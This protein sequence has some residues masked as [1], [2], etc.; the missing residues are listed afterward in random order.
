MLLCAVVTIGLLIPPAAAVEPAP[1]EDLYSPFNEAQEWPDIDGN[2]IVWEDDRHDNK[3][4]YF[5]TV[6]KFRAD[7]YRGMQY[8]S[9]TG[10]RITDDPASQERPSISGNYIVWQD[11]RHGNWDI[12]LYDRSTGIETQLTT[13]TGKQWLPIVR[14]NYV[15]WYDDSSGDTNIVLYDIAAGSVKDV[16]ECDAK[17]TIPGGD[18]DTEF[19]PALSEKYVAWVEEA[20]ERIRYY[21][22]ND[23]EIKG[24]VSTGTAIQS[25]PSL[26]GSVVAWEDNRHGNPDIYMTDLDDPSGG[27]QRI[28]SDSADQV[29]PAI[30]GSIIVW[31][32]KRVPARSI[33]MYDLSAEK[34][35]SVVLSEDKDDE[36]LYPAVSGN[37]IV[38]QRGRE[39]DSNLYIF[40]Y[41]PGAPVE[42]I[43]D[44]VTVTPDTA[45]LEIDGTEQFTATAF[46]QFGEEMAGAEFAWACSN[47]TV[48]TI[49]DTGFFTAHAAGTT[50]VT[51]TAEDIAGTATVT[52]TADEPEEPVLDSIEVEPETVTLEIDGTQ[53]FAATAL[54]QFEEEM[55]GIAFNWSCD[56]ETVGEIDTDGIFTALAAGTATITATAE[57]IT[58]TATVTVTDEEP[59]ATEITIEPP[60]ATLDVNE[61]VT[62]EATVRDQFGGEVPGVS[63]T[64]SCDNETVGAINESSGFFTAHAAGTATVTATAGDLSET[65]TITVTADEPEEPV[66][67]R[68]EV[69]PDTATLDVGDTEQFAAIA[70]DE[71]GLEMTGVE[72]AWSCDNE[73]IG[74]V[75]DTGLFS[76]LASGTATVTASAGD[77]SGTAT[78]TVNADEP[79]E[80]VLTRIT[81]TPPGA[82]LD[83]ED[84]Q[85]FMVTGYDQDDNVMP[86]G[87]ID[88]ACSDEAVGTVDEDGCFT[89]LAAGTATVTATAGNCS[90]EATITVCEEEPLLAKIAV[91]PSKATLEVDDELEFDAIAFDRFGNIVEDA[92]VIWECCDECVGEIDESSG[93]FTA[94]GGGTATITACGDGAEGTAS[95][96]V[97][98]NDPVVTS[99]VV[100]PSAVTLARNDTATFTATALDQN[101]CGMS[102]VTIEWE[103]SDKTVGDVDGTGFFE[104]LAAGTAT[105]TAT[106]DGVAGTADVEVTDES[107]G[108]VVSPSAIILDVDETW[109]FNA[110]VYD[111]QDNA[112][113]TVAWSCGNEGVGTIT[114]DGGLFTAVCEGITSVTATVA[115]ENETATG[116][117][118]VTVRSTAPE[119]ARIEVS[120]SC[121][122]I[123]AG[124]CL[125]L[126]ARGFDQYGF[127]MDVNVTWKSSDLCVGEIDESS[128]VFTAKSA[129]TATLTASADGVCDSACVTV[130]PSLPVPACIEVE[131]P[132]ATLAAGGTREFTATVFDQCENVMDWVRVAW[133]C[134][135][136]DVGTIDRSG[137]FAAFAE[138]SADVTA[139]AGGVEGTASVAVTAAPTTDPT[140]DPTPDP[141]Q[142]PANPG[143][144]KRASSSGGG[145]PGP[146]FFAGICEDLKGGET[147]TFS[148]IDITSIGSIAITASDNIPKLLM[149]VKETG[150][151]NLAAP[152]GGSTYEYV[153]IALSWAN[154]NRVG[155]AT[156]TFTVPAKWLEEHDMLPQD[157]RLMRYVDGGW[158]ILETEV[159]GEEDGNYCFRATTPGFSTF[160]IAAMPENATVTTETNVTTE[161]TGTPE[162]AE[163]MTTGPTVAA[164]TTPA[165]PLVYAPL[166]AP[167]AFLLWA[168]KRR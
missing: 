127:P 15:A 163:T 128:G 110:N 86:A 81:L 25:W 113:S 137:L 2:L 48:G 9:Y 91:V 82:T 132:D 24:A 144:N 22:I 60:E 116:T 139:C 49:D 158:Q 3:D 108:I 121:F 16:I 17:M 99:I 164:T 80:P 104:A 78:V 98:C 37:T 57:D 126:T 13:D 157:V 62:F 141:T 43:L 63:V 130:D 46:D 122:C 136:D 44:R 28:T 5:G 160:A 56:N 52:V 45:T 165:A 124:N 107:T 73:T 111:L 67:E 42:P 50:D 142:P 4:I 29:A 154:P 74:T 18:I 90:A 85:R 10:E 92:E 93:V 120:P 53:Q 148:G 70:F 112:G 145:D 150:C 47:T 94:L 31:E 125:A 6:D 119:L 54:D 66:L 72:F 40:V 1:G 147:H 87:E 152:P 167:L 12:Y 133:S 26:Y 114:A 58:G 100:T 105:V 59:A 155:D 75:D 103:C 153:E 38:W 88:W 161:A 151:P 129:G 65:A 7:P 77:V 84:V 30:S 83:V 11:Y 20:G 131:P 162:G 68:I 143:S 149:T 101:G 76:A 134:S 117:A 106:A 55:T 159:V 8:S 115:G 166:L 140:T 123:P 69:E 89:A 64:W 61:T 23:G 79:E 36:H 19:K 39:S 156:L 95:V 135:D 33:F 21:S 51:A 32:D 34:E 109:Q 96:T 102:D 14:G 35:M 71:N 27:E 138:G 118:T 97:H 168:R 146:S 41:E